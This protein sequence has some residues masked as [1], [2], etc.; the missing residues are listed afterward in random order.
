MSDVA[1]WLSEAQGTVATAQHVLFDLDRGLVAA[2]KVERVARR[3]RPVL[4]VTV[5]MV[6]GGL[7][8]LG[9]VLIV[10]RR[11]SQTTPGTFDD[12]PRPDGEI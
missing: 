7:I 9:V 11:R 1:A 6:V 8:G 12:E 2:E 10:N 5:V 4:R 3:A